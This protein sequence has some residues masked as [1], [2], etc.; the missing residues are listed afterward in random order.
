MV[1]LLHAGTC[2]DAAAPRDCDEHSADELHQSARSVHHHDAN[3]KSASAAER[4]VPTQTPVRTPTGIAGGIRA[5]VLSA[6][7]LVFCRQQFEACFDN[8]VDTPAQTSNRTRSAPAR[9]H[10]SGADAGT[11]R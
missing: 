5:C 6:K 1:A 11:R 4:P 9:F 3:R 2:R 10:G 8:M 7:R